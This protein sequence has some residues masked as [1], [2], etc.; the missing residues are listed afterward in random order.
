MNDHNALWKDLLPYQLN[1]MLNLNQR[2]TLY[3]QTQALRSC[4][5][6]VKYL[7]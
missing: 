7:T 6:K 5:Y 2:L 4:L 3:R 1:L